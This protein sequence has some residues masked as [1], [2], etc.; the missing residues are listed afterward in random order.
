MGITLKVEWDDL[1]QL[2][3][4][5]RNLPEEVAKEV[6]KAQEEDLRDVASVLA[7]YPP[8]LPGTHYE[9]TGNLGLGWIESGPKI[10]ILGGG[11]N[12]TATL[13]NPV[14]Y[15]GEVQGGKGD[16]EHQTAEFKRR[17]WKTTDQALDETEARAQKRLEAAVQ[18]ALDRLGKSNGNGKGK[19]EM[20]DPK[21]TARVGGDFSDLIKGSENAAKS[22]ASLGMKAAALANPFSLAS[23]AIGGTLSVLGKLGMASIGIEAVGKSAVSMANGLL[24]GNA[25]LEMTTISF[26][27]LLVQRLGRQRYDPAAYH[28][29]RPN[30]L[31][32]ARPGSLHPEAPGFRLYPEANHPPHDQPGR[33]HFSPGRQPGQP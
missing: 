26:K 14:P 8:Q 13:S 24:A 4:G 17:H 32:P 31:Q 15:A 19:E 1:D 30:P 9:R 29:C 3:A 21:S 16:S 25:R 33:Y 23:G 10:N 5:I 22:L 7:D 12:F 20:A 28:L 2:I 18:K 27:T 6:Q 11:L